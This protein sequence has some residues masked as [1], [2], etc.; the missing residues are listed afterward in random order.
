MQHFH[1]T[2][3][4]PSLS[5]FRGQFIEKVSQN[6]K[7]KIDEKWRYTLKFHVYL[8]SMQAL[9]DKRKKSKPHDINLVAFSL[10]RRQFTTLTPQEKIAKYFEKLKLKIVS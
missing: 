3:L 9:S 1:S 8:K 5:L 4:L 7:P 10:E 6:G 2:S